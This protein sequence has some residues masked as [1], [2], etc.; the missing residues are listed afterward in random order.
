[1]FLISDIA[2]VIYE[3]IGIA[4]MLCADIVFFKKYRKWKQQQEHDGERKRY[5]DLQDALKNTRR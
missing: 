2:I 1:M 5:V 4:V 3:T